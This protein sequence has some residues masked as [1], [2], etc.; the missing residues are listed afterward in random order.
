M[1]R[2]SYCSVRSKPPNGSSFVSKGVILYLQRQRHLGERGQ[3]KEVCHTLL[4]HKHGDQLL[5]AELFH[6]ERAPS[7]GGRN[8]V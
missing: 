8:K 6:S 4:D 2:F 7:H 5:A 1:E 3:E